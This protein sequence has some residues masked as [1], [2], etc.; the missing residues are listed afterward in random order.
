MANLDVC[1]CPQYRSKVKTLYF[2]E[3]TQ[4]GVYPSKVKYKWT[5]VADM[6]MGCLAVAAR[7]VA[8]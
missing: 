8:A 5:P 1:S 2:R 6:C 3:Q 4:S 7:K